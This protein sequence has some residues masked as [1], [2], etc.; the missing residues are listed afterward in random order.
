M[1]RKRRRIPFVLHKE[2]NPNYEKLI[3]PIPIATEISVLPRDVMIVIFAKL[4]L[5]SLH[6][7][8]KVNHYWR[9][10]SFQHN[11]LETAQELEEQTIDHQHIHEQNAHIQRRRFWKYVQ[12]Q[13]DGYFSLHSMKAREPLLYY[14]YLGQF[15][16]KFSGQDLVALS[17]QFLKKEKSSEKYQF[18]DRMEELL[19]EAEMQLAD[20]IIEQNKDTLEISQEDCC[21]E[22]EYNEFF[23]IMRHKF[24]SGMDRHFDYTECDND[25]H[26]D[27]ECKVDEYAA[28]E[29]ICPGFCCLE[30]NDF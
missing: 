18:S 19:R 12:L 9:W 26:L 4:D 13:D 16:D 29:Y 21:F 30:E 25:E 27:K 23:R 24:M 1:K 8:A 10:A 6:N 20:Q 3:Q 15:E 22:I 17:E 11:H 14:E 2:L 7:C 28:E 5:R